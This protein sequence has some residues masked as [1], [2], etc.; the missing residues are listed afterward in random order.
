MGTQT[1]SIRIVVADDQ[2]MIRQALATLLNLE[3]GFEVVG[4]AGNG[5]DLLELVDADSSGVDVVALDVEMP[6]LD[7]LTACAA[8][9]RK[10]PGLKVLMVTT[11]GRPGYV[12]RA[13]EAG[14]DGFVVKDA[15]LAELSGAVRT[16]YSGGRV[17]GSNLAVEALFGGDSPLTPRETEVLSKLY[18]GA[19][20][21][22]V[23]AE[24]GLSRGT[25]RNY[26]SSAMDKLAARNGPEAAKI[27]WDKG[28]L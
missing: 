25:I 13:L 3:P 26:V 14:A 15:P 9:K 27:A 1:D 23:A 8:L 10:H 7:G 18:E 2:A 16:V 19:G 24:L 4:T 5:K 12:Q 6:E 11:F 22:D 21:G 28:W 17:L 20:A